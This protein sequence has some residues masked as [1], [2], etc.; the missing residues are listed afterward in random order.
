MRPPFH[1]SSAEELYY[2]ALDL[3]A[4]GDAVGAARNL[5]RCLESTQGNDRRGGSRGTAGQ[6]AGLEE[7][8]AANEA[9]AVNE[10]KSH[11][12]PHPLCSQH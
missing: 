8:A 9:D 6:A 3:L 11:H 7:T 2:E 10:P 1:S 5:R 12:G 4:E